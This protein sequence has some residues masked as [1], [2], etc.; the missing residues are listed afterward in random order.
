MNP[1]SR[2][3]ILDEI[4]DVRAGDKGNGLI[5]AVLPRSSGDYEYLVSHLTEQVVA[6]H[7]GMSTAG[8]WRSLAPGIEAMSFWLDDLLQGGVTGSTQLDGHGKT[9]GY[10]LL[11]LRLQDSATAS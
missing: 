3:I 9:L 4:A 8:V 7:F 11:T 1:D 10:H 2:T 6:G 5:L